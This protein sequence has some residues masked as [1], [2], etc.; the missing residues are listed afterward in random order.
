MPDDKAGTVV[1]E[2][3][4]EVAD[5]QAQAETEATATDTQQTQTSSPAKATADTDDSYGYDAP[6]AE[7]VSEDTGSDVQDTDRTG[8]DE[9]GSPA[10]SGDEGA[11]QGEE[12][13]TPTLDA[14]LVAKA[15]ELGL[16]HDEAMGIG[17]DAVLEKLIV[18]MGN[19][20]TQA[21]SAQTQKAPEAVGTQEVVPELKLDLPENVV[22]AEVV[23]AFEALKAH[24]DARIAQLEGR[25]EQTNSEVQ[26]LVKTEDVRAEREMTRWADG[27]FAA[28]GTEYV[29]LFGKGERDS[30]AP[31]TD[32]F[33]NRGQVLQTMD[34]ISDGREQ[35]GL[36]ELSGDTLF[37]R[38]VHSLF[39]NEVQTTVR[40]QIAGK[41]DK[42]AGQFTA[43]PTHRRGKDAKTP[44]DKEVQDTADY[45]EE[46]GIVADGEAL[47]EGFPD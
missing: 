10:E 18:A 39:S 34:V 17:S 32:A 45:Q 46:H 28:L 5:E 33:K 30:L 22:E 35:N 43:R 12:L 19:T 44:H 21:E 47:N 1:A 27:K 40:K 11:A 4:G 31:N 14:A 24:Y 36:P 16:T 37:T 6:D 25:Q 42:R 7:D 23:G 29:G 41:V 38:A 3:T 15:E 8:G 9:E 13:E 2:Q 26:G 20:A